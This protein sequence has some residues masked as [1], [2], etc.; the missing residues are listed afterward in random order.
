MSNFPDPPDAEVVLREK[1]ESAVSTWTTSSLS[2]LKTHGWTPSGLSS[3]LLL[4]LLTCSFIFYT[5]T[6]IWDTF[7]Q[8]LPLKKLPSIGVYPSSSIPFT[9]QKSTELFLYGSIFSRC[10]F[11]ILNNLFA[12]QSSQTLGGSLIC[13]RKDLLLF[14]VY[15]ASWPWNLLLAVYHDFVFNPS[16]VIVPSFPNLDTI[17][18][19][20]RKPSSSS[21]IPYHAFYS[22]FLLEILFFWCIG[23]ASRTAA[24]NM[25]PMK[26]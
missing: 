10:F 4:I 7:S 16:E 19:C 14:F 21:N 13:S 8:L 22:V 5:Y 24:L 15:F 18:A 9:N 1:L 12:L 11:C 23:S 3:W 17:S 25:P 2:C 26:T 20:W 6:W